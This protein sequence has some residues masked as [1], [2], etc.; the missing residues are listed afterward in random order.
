MA[1]SIFI[2]HGVATAGERPA[3]VRDR[4]SES[5]LADERSGT[6]QG[7]YRPLDQ[8]ERAQRCVVLTLTDAA[9]C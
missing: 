7:A 1:T 9:R 4:S 5:F 3:P 8:P 2:C 6:R